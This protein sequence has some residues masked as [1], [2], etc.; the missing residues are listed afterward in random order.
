MKNDYLDLRLQPSIGQSSGA[1]KYP[2]MQGQLA[3]ATPLV[4]VLA[5]HDRQ[6]PAGSED[7]RYFPAGQAVQEKLSLT[8]D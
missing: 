2:A 7:E 4:T 5:G 3:T 1:L 8:R 6:E